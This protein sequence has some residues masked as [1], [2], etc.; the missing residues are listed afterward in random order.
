[1][2]LTEMLSKLRVA[3]PVAYDEIIRRQRIPFNQIRTEYVQ[4]NLD[5][6]IQGCCQRAIAAR[7]WHLLQSQDVDD[8]QYYA[9]ISEIAPGYNG[10]CHTQRHLYLIAEGRDD[11]PSAALLSAYLKAVEA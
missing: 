7:G 2:Q 9:E 3:D 11:S 4:Q 8:N 10:D 1:M 5:D 6:I